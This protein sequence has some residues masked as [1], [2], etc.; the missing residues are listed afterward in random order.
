MR[1]IRK[2]RFIN[3]GDFGLSAEFIAGRLS[4]AQ[5]L[6]DQQK[7]ETNV[8]YSAYLQDLVELLAVGIAYSKS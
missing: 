6:H 1:T 4:D 7:K 8:L 3:K 2:F 5:K